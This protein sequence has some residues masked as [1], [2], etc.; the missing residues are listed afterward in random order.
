MMLADLEADH[1][2]AIILGRAEA[3]DAR[4]AGDDDHVVAADQGAGA[5]QAEPLDLLVDRGVLLDVDVAL[6]DVGFGLVVVVIADEVAD[7]VVR[8]E[9]L[10]LAVE[11]GGERLVVRHDQRGP[12]VLGDHVGHRE[13]L[14]R[15]G[16]AQQ[17]LVALALGA[18]L[19]QLSIAW[20]WSPAGWNGLTSWNLDMDDL[21]SKRKRSACNSIII[22]RRPAAA[23]RNR[24]T[25]GG[26][27]D[28][29]R[30]DSND[31]QDTASHRGAGSVVDDDQDCSPWVTTSRNSRARRARASTPSGS[32]GRGTSG[33]EDVLAAERHRRGR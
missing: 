23:N 3:V 24:P 10:E 18:A 11:L 14:A 2:L 29:R 33:G 20:G 22:R 30:R 9:L 5:G 21:I 1:H 32:A 12:P 31:P 19:D 6:G 17:R 26:L 7:G 25:P 27:R 8:E 15:A 4:D 13:R 28:D 16:D